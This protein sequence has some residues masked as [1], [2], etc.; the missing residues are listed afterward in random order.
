MKDSLLNELIR[1][2]NDHDAYVKFYANTRAML[3]KPDNYL[4][5][6]PHQGLIVD[7]G[8]GYGI[9]ANYMSLY[10]SDC[11]I[12]GIDMN[13]KRIDVALKTVGKRENINFIPMDVTQ[14]DWPCCAG[15]TMTS[16]LH[17]IHKDAQEV[18]L[19]KAFQGM[20]KNATLLIMEVDIAIKPVYKYWA[21]YMSDR[22]LYPLSRSYFRSSADWENILSHLGF[23]V[24]I[25]KLQNPFFSGILLICRK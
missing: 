25:K 18:V 5:F 14:W 12:I 23:D 16:F 2:Y 22:V 20:E 3:L 9:L 8:C 10:Y 6:L 4:E 19:Q 7:V 17:H 15:V 21:S 13:R 11:K 24:Q 1:L